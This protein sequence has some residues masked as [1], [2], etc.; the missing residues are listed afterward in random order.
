[1]CKKI[2]TML[3]L[4][5]ALAVTQAGFGQVIGA[6]DGG[7]AEAGWGK[8]DNGVQPLDADVFT[9]TDLPG[10]NGGALETSLAGF[11]DSFGYSFSTGGTSAAFFNNTQLVFDAIYRGTF[12]D[13]GDSNNFS[14][15]F[16]VIFQSDFQ[17]FQTATFT[18]NAD[19]VA[20]S[21]FGG[22]GTSVGW[23]PEDP[24]SVQTVMNVTID[25]TPMLN[26]LV[27]NGFSAASPPAVLQFWMSTNDANR[28]FKAID[29]V[30]LIPEPASM[31]LLALGGLHIASRRRTAA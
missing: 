4:V 10:T 26:F 18:L 12:V 3:G 13:T 31:G 17:S 14:Q 6:F 1:M 5:C 7:V 23:A 9:V 28:P 16:Q 11:S 24:G 15:V 30:R 2:C 8:F 21:Q 22:G 19:G 20:L 29:N 25:Y 27:T